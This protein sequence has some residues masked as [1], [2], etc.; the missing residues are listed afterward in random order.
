MWADFLSHFVEM[1]EDNREAYEETGEHRLKE[2]RKNR[3][4]GINTD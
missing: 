3:L 4:A 1:K 2:E